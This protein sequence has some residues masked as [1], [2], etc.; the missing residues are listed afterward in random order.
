MEIIKIQLKKMKQKLNELF[1]CHLDISLRVL[2]LEWRWH[3]IL[4]IILLE[5]ENLLEDKRFSSD[6]NNLL[7]LQ[8]ITG[9]FQDSS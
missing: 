4:Y 6:Y 5:T 1:H 2:P 3:S 7:N 8:L 9:L